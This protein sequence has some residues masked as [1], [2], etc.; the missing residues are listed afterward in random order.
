[1]RPLQP[2]QGL[3]RQLNLRGLLLVPPEEYV[4]CNDRRISGKP[5]LIYGV[6]WYAAESEAL[7]APASASGPE[8][9]V[10]AAEPENETWMKFSR[11]VCEFG[12]GGD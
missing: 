10:E 4:T 12:V 11:A 5:G 8:K 2:L 6:S 7:E 9:L 1:M 3:E